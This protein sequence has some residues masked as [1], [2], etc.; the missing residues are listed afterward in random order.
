VAAAPLV[1]LDRIVERSLKK[2]FDRKRKEGMLDADL[3]EAN[4]REIWK[5]V[6]QGW[7]QISKA[8]YA[9]PEH[10]KLIQMRENVAIFNVFKNHESQQEIANT[11]FD[12]KGALRKWP[13]FKKEALKISTT[14]NKRY[15]QA[16]YQAAQALGRSA[17][18]WQK[19]D[20]EK[21]QLPYLTFKTVGDGRVRD[22]H[23][24]LDGATYPVDDPFWSTYFPPIGW[25]CR[26]RVIQSRKPG[27]KAKDLPEVHKVFQNNPGKSGEVFTKDHPYFKEKKQVNQQM[28]AFLERV[29]IPRAAQIMQNIQSFNALKRGDYS[30]I[31]TN[32]QT[33]GWYA[34]RKEADPKDLRLNKQYA[35][36]MTS[37][38][39]DTV[40]IR[41]HINKDGVKN[42][43]ALI[44]SKVADF[45]TPD[46]KLYKTVKGPI[47]N[48]AVKGVEQ[49]ASHVVIHLETKYSQEH[50]LKGILDA[51][52]YANKDGLRLE[53]LDIKFRNESLVRVRLEDLESGLFV[54]ILK[55]GY[56][57]PK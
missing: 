51:F 43:E 17:G 2:V 36:D 28:D 29:G 40:V 46:H 49:G 5:G 32:S 25:R 47:K 55:N 23:S 41:E 8:E 42:P 44:N 1:D 4:T 52:H 12:E 33:G 24:L 9:S 7:K 37:L 39:P 31:G 18:Q 34:I 16:E 30:A 53:V 57:P 21:E 35:K 22:S 19:Y 48:M 15:L 26:C 10:I 13:A 56:V 11:L 54:Q 45:K 27:P 38:K 20:S 50:I 3:W 6:Q 14:Y